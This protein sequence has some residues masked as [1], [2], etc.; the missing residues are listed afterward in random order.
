[1]KTGNI[2]GFVRGQKRWRILWVDMQHPVD[3]RQTDGPARRL[4]EPA[5]DG[6][7]TMTKMRRPPCARPGQGGM[8]LMF[9]V[10]AH[11]GQL[12]GCVVSTVLR[13]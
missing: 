11:H 12:L 8:G 10:M 5:A 6:R 13:T 7:T 1:M 4:P 3:G 9:M 2:S